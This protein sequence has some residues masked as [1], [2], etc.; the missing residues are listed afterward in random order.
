MLILMRFGDV[1]RVTTIL[2]MT[3]I[4]VNLPAVGKVLAQSTQIEV[5]EILRKLG[6]KGIDLLEHVRH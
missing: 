5:D 2:L 4:C 6:A 1:F 3:L